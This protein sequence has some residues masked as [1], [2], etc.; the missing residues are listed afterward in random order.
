[1]ADLLATQQ[2]HTR[3]LLDLPNV[4]GVK[5]G[6]KRTHGVDTG[7]PCIVVMV[8][9]K[10]AISALATDHV[11]PPNLDGA[12]TDVVEEGE[13]R[14][15]VTNAPPVLT[16]RLLTRPLVGGVSISRGLFGGTGS[17]GFPMLF[18]DGKDLVGLSNAHVCASFWNDPSPVPWWGQPYVVKVGASLFQPGVA[19]DGGPP[20]QPIGSLIDWPAGLLDPGNLQPDAAIFGY[21][22]PLGVRPDILGIGAC[23]GFLAPQVGQTVRSSGRTSGNADGQVTA[24]GA[25][26]KVTVS[27]G[28]TPLEMVAEDVV[29]LSPLMQPG[30]SGTGIF[31]GTQAVALGFAGSSQHSYAYAM[32]RIAA[33]W[34][35]TLAPTNGRAPAQ[36]VLASLLSPRRVLEACWGFDAGRQTFQLFNPD[37]AVPAAV[38]DLKELVAGEAYWLN[39]SD[40]AVLE[41]LGLRKALAK[42]WNLVGACW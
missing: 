28:P 20:A 10:V 36:L 14:L 34:G 8:R 40:A 6:T 3:R 1:M 2:R 21:A 7:I 9:R 25:T 26:I 18:R 13:I 12:T 32:A 31:A 16:Q 19:D 17:L 23:S 41:Y 42:G 11:V 24:L 35:L 39:L 5:V 27:A 30:D 22:D 33:T 15:L 37:T 38:S 29:E 4:V